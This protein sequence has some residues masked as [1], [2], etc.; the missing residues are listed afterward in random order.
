MQGLITNVCVPHL[1]VEQGL[2][3]DVCFASIQNTRTYYDMQGLFTERH[4]APADGDKAAMTGLLQVRRCC[5][6]TRSCERSTG[7]VGYQQIAW[8][9]Y[10]ELL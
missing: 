10:N 7:C 8:V 6:L 9:I 4:N 2:F 1:Y 3:T 5:F